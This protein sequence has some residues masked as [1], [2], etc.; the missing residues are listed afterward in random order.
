MKLT[1]YAKRLYEVVSKLDALA[2]DAGNVRGI[3]DEQ[4]EEAREV[5]SDI[6]VGVNDLAARLDAA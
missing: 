1:T 5:L 3:T 2:A 6:A 4:K